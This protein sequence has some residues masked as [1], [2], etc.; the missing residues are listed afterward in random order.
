MIGITASRLV[1]HRWRKDDVLPINTINADPEVMRW[2]DDGSVC[3]IQQTRAAIDADGRGSAP[4]R[5]DCSQDCS[6][7]AGQHPTHVDNS[8][9][10]AQASVL[11]RPDMGRALVF[12]NREFYLR[13]DI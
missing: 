13:V 3:D 4:F 6:Q 12:S 5:R 7:A 9:I 8:G 11:C 2:M 1:P 10:S